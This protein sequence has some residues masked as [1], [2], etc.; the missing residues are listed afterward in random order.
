MGIPFCFGGLVRG[1]GSYPPTSEPL[2][3]R[4]ADA[5]ARKVSGPNQGLPWQAAS[6]PTA[7]P[8]AARWGSPSLH[9]RR[10]STP[11]WVHQPRPAM[12][13]P[14]VTQITGT[15]G[16]YLRLGPVNGPPA[17]EPRS[18]PPSRRA[19]LGGSDPQLPINAWCRLLRALRSAATAQEIP[20]SL[21]ARPSFASS[22]LI[23]GGRGALRRHVPMRFAQRTREIGIRTRRSVHSLET[24][25][26]PCSPGRGSPPRAHEIGIVVSP[27]L[28]TRHGDA[29][30]VWRVRK[31]ARSN[32]VFVG[33]GRATRAV[34]V[35]LLHSG[36]PV[37]MRRRIPL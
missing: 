35:R 13:L 31:P 34:L 1:R 6:M 29:L 33:V 16:R 5:M 22:P 27:G 20:T 12:Y 23:L 37:R 28:T 25:C 24:C 17:T 30:L 7:A 3:R 8:P 32:D 18:A 36:A 11:T 2:D 10:F 26:S 21:L 4:L 14:P 15:R 19:V 9:R